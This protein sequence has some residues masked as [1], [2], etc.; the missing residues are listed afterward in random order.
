MKNQK[1]NFFY[2][3]SSTENDKIKATLGTIES[4]A[5]GFNGLFCKEEFRGKKIIE[6]LL[7]KEFLTV[8]DVGSGKKGHAKYLSDHGKKVYTNGFT[9]GNNSLD[10]YDYIGDFNSI[11]F[12]K[13]FDVTLC[14]HVLEHQ[15]NV[16]E[17]LTNVVNV[18]KKNGYIVI[19]VP[20]RKPFVIGGHVSIWNAGLILYNMILAG[21]DCSKECHIKQYDYNIGLIVKNVPIE[22]NIKEI[23]TYD[24]G[25]IDNFLTKYFPLEAHDGFNGDIMEL[26]W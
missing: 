1:Y 21:V 25:D 2:R 15:L 18:T 14:S 8:I 13:K 10:K 23:I 3:S 7:E 20:P 6:K 17:F 26:N 9:K 4:D 22:E 19:I 11:K 24:G 5:S 16:H 12:D